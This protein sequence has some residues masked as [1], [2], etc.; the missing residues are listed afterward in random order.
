MMPYGFT[1]PEPVQTPEI[2]IQEAIRLS[3]FQEK[4]MVVFFV[5]LATTDCRNPQ[6]IIGSSLNVQGTL[7]ASHNWQ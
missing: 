4:Y 6:P 3:E 2:Y 5:S 1:R 7:E